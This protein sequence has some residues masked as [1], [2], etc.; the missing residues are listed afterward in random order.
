MNMQAFKAIVAEAS[1]RQRPDAHS[2]SQSLLTLLGDGDSIP[3]CDLKVALYNVPD[4]VS[5]RIHVHTQL[6]ILDMH[7]VF[8][9]SFSLPFP[10]CK[11]ERYRRVA[12]GR[13]CGR[14]RKRL[15]TIHHR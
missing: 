7:T 1:A 8:I 5:V 11:R 10:V 6:I 12:K 4:S 15:A 13:S 14:T 3:L 9:F 2:L